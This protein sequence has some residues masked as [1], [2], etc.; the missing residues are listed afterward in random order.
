MSSQS[1]YVLEQKLIAQLEELGYKKVAV[2]NEK[3]LVNNL[4]TQLEIF[5]KTKFSDTEFEKILNHLSKGTIF[6]KA[7][8]L[9]GKFHFVR[10]DGS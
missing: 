9:R 6:E 2:S 8:T 7:K 3:E 5:N 4:K 1:E 10:D